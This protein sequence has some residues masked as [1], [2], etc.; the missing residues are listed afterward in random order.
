MNTVSTIRKHQ[1][2][3]ALLASPEISHPA[4]VYDPLSMR[5]A[6]QHGFR[7]TMLA[8]SVA[9]LAILGAPDLVILTSSELAALCRRLCRAGDLP[10]LVDADHGFGDALHVYR[11]VQELETAGVSA[12][13]IEDTLLPP[14]FG[15]TGPERLIPT[16]EAVGKIK[17][18]VAAR[19][20]ED[21]AIIGRTSLSRA[22]LDDITERVAAYEA[23]GADAIFLSGPKTRKQIAAV[24]S[25]TRLPLILGRITHELDDTDFL[26]KHRVR[27]V[28][29]GHKPFLASLQAMHTTLQ[30]LAG[31]TAASALTD[32][33][34]Q[35]LLDQLSR[36]NAYDELIAQTLRECNPRTPT[37]NP[38]ETT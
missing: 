7:L 23:A 17:A 37:I 19:S 3:R 10:L 28:L 22:P 36:K 11:T 5:S 27:I 21:M 14:P 12:L 35:A 26:A 8:G 38:E 2:F 20:H 24:A 31:G 15:D 25:A 18:A 9:S 16:L 13:T 33:A 4:S 30:Q 1:Q 29:Q 32:T 6:A 34:P